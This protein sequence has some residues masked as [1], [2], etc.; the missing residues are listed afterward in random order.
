[1]HPRPFYTTFNRLSSVVME[2]FLVHIIPTDIKITNLTGIS[3][4]TG[5]TS[6]L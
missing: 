5:K 2:Y 6:V 1:M 4:K 3:T